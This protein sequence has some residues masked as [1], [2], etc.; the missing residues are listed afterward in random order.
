[1]GGPNFVKRGNEPYQGFHI[2]QPIVTPLNTMDMTDIFTELAARIGIL[3]NYNEGINRTMLMDP[4]TKGP[5]PYSLKPERKYTVEEIVDAQCR[6]VTSGK[7]GLDW[8][9]ENGGYFKPYP[10][11]ETYHYRRW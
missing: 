8:F 7:F 11:L 4:G 2:R 3:E 9:K 5:G 1:M 10:R 6:T